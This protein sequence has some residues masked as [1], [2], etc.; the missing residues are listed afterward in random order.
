MWAIR[1]VHE[2]KMYSQNCFL[3]LTYDND[4]LP[5]GGTLVLRDLQLFLKRLHNKLLRERG[6]GIRYF[7]AGEYGEENGRPHYHALV[8]GYQFTDLRKYKQNARGE[9]VFTSKSLEA[10]W[11]LGQCKIGAV[12][13]ASAAYVARY[14]L[15]KVDGAKREA[16][17][18]ESV[19][20]DGVVMERLPEFA[21]MSRRPGIG[22]A[23]YEKYGGEIRAHD[24]VII[25]G[26]PVPSIRYYDLKF[27]AIDGVKFAAT[28]RKRGP[29]SVGE[30][31]ER[32]DEAARLRRIQTK[33][34]EARL[35]L[36]ARKL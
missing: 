10:L 2:S 34:L 7:A 18:Y 20:A 24:N 33:L 6:F 30:L 36:K 9:M 4:H 12:T 11:G 5:S 13:Y 23:Y 22:T 35:K 14:A 31:R 26:K 32:L 29:R 1:C 27:E 8:F 15:K 17:H 25:D 19:S 21:L 16:G 28:K 3:T